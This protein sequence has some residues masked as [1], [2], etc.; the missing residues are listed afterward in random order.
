MHGV[1][2]WGPFRYRLVDIWLIDNENN[3]YINEHLATL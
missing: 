1:S 3:L 2:I